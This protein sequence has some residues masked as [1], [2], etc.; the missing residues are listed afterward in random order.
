MLNG[1]TIFIGIGHTESIEGVSDRIREQIAKQLVTMLSKNG[2]RVYYG[3]TPDTY[4]WEFDNEQQQ[5]HFE[6][7]LG[8]CW[9]LIHTNRQALQW[10]LNECENFPPEYRNVIQKRARKEG[11]S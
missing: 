3:N 7:D 10:L 6:R 4:T 11:L 8:Q 1:N 9:S 5:Q 2:W